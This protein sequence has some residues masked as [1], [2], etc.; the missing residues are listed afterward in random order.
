MAFLNR[1]SVA[2]AALAITLILPS[3]SAHAAPANVPVP[4]P[5]PHEPKAQDGSPGAPAQPQPQPP[6]DDTDAPVP[7]KRPAPPPAATGDE[8]QQKGKETPEPETEKKSGEKGAP[9]QS[10]SVPVP[11]KPE[12]KAE[13]AACYKDLDALGVTY[14]KEKTIN[15]AGQCGIV[16][17]VSVK[18][19]QPDIPLKPDAV[20]R[21]R[22]ALQLARWTKRVVEPAAEELGK[23][24]RL[25]GLAQ[26]SAYVCKK[27]DSLP[28]GKISEHAF[29]DAIDIVT[30]RFSGHDS[31]SI[32]PRDRTGTI[33]ES[34]Q[35]AV[36]GG[37]CLYFTTVLGP[38]ADSY[39]QDNLHLDVMERS[40]GF[41][42]CQ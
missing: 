33:E 26:G 35:R 36:V 13:L 37:A 18:E 31:I 2:G 29:G 21:C 10:Q 16:S 17:P 20:M 32:A 1:R 24:V 19:I 40:H 3:L 9:E 39:H 23:G 11:G 5:K 6:A 14:T 15:D 4:A 27:R 12:D 41:R 25:T 34:F 30:F 8:P 7:E 28:D 42:L 38:H 22:T